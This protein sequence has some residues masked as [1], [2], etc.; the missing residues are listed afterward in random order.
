MPIQILIGYCRRSLGMYADREHSLR[1]FSGEIFWGIVTFQ[2]V[3]QSL[4]VQ[5][6]DGAPEQL[7]LQ[8]H[9]SP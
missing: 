5:R 9:V 8:R 7:L 2:D 4:H 3:T 1:I 6:Y